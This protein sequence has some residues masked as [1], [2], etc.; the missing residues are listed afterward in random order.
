MRLYPEVKVKRK[1]Y[2]GVKSI[3]KPSQSMSLSEIIR[4]FTRNEAIPA[5]KEGVYIDGL[6]DL[7]K[8]CKEDLVIQHERIEEVKQ[9]VKKFKDEEEE[10][11]R[12]AAASEEEAKFQARFKKELA[13]RKKKSSASTPSLPHSGE[14]SS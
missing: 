1:S 10:K 14:T 7:E 13:K 4:R 11:S 8:M 12:T 6:G 9:K 5:S 2:A 3:V